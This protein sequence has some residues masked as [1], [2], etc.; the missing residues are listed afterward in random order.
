MPRRPASTRTYVIVWGWLMGLA[1]GSCLLSFA[2]LGAFAPVVALSIGLA[3]AALIVAFFM[4]LAGQP[5]ICRWA[6]ALGIALA[7]LLLIM[8]GADVLTRETPGLAQPGLTSDA[9]VA[10]TAQRTSP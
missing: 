1:L 10:A 5:S 3:K 4:N 6:F 2:H 8:V 9:P 7:A